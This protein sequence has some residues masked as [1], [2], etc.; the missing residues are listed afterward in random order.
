M[1]PGW[2]PSWW[3]ALCTTSCADDQDP[4][5]MRATSLAARVRAAA[6]SLTMAVTARA[7]ALR[8]QGVPVISFAPGEPDFATPAHVVTAVSQALASDPEI[9]RYPPVAGI[10]PLR[11]A[12]AA[13]LRRAH[14]LEV[15]LEQILVTSGAKQA[16]FNCLLAAVDHGDEVVVLAPYWVSYPEIVKLAGGT[17]VVVETSAGERFL[18]DP[19]RVAAALSPRTRA[20]LLNSPCNPTGAVLDR[21]TLGAIARLAVERDLLLV[22]DDIYRAF[23]YDGASYTSVAGLAPEVAARTVIIDGVSKTYGMTGWRIGYAAGP[24]PLIAAML[25][26]QSQSTSSACRVAQVAATAALEG[27]QDC[28]AAMLAAFTERRA[29]MV[30]GLGQIPGLR[31]LPPQG[32]FYL[33]ADVSAH[34]GTTTGDGTRIADDVALCN[35]LVERAQVAVV[36]GSGF[37]APGHIRLSYTCALADIEEG[38]RRIDQ[39]LR[40]LHAAA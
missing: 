12:I 40:A 22:C 36:P 26:L 21:A 1:S 2:F 10:A 15:P 17:P 18:P 20:I 19:A 5:P 31:F 35:Y 28:V 23:L 13:E 30:R 14:G 34:L 7:A 8:A 38:T 25:T 24:A 29:A 32:A 11:Q 16:L 27:P 33:F 37:G 4:L 6:P 39:A 9:G 3:N